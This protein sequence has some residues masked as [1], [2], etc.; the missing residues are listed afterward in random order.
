M[1]NLN[2]METLKLRFHWTP[3]SST[4]C[5]LP[6]SDTCVWYE[7]SI[8]VQ[9]SWPSDLDLGPEEDRYREGISVP[10]DQQPIL[11]LDLYLLIPTLNAWLY[12]GEKN[13]RIYAM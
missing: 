9:P 3:G 2:T 6:P 8:M 7:Y 1:D 10:T 11:H 4:P 5:N 12:G 13:M